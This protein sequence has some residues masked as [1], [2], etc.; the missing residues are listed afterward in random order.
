[1]EEHVKWLSQN[2]EK[3]PKLDAHVMRQSISHFYS[4]GS[5]CLKTGDKRETEVNIINFL[6]NI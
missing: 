2:E 6:N 4:S 1:M 3:K 5:V